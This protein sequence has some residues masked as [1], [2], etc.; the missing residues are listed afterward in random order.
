MKYIHKYIYKGGDKAT[1]VIEGEIDEIERYLHGR[2]VG[3]TKA[4]WRLFEFRMHEEF[5]AIVHLAIHLPGEQA[6]YFTGDE[7]LE[8]LQNRL[9]TAHSTL[10]AF[11]DHNRD[12]ADGR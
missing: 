1:A 3:P 7:D 8:V 4:I 5:P 11:F 12:V 6:V 10:T 2:Y 9:E